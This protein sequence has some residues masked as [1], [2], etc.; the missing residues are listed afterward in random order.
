VE[1]VLAKGMGGSAGV[2]VAGAA[3]AFGVQ[4]ALARLLGV[5]QYGVY[6]FVLSWVGLLILVARLGLDVSAVRFVP[7]Y[8][9]RGEWSLL[10]GLLRTSVLAVA[11]AGIVL[12][13]G[14]ALA[15]RFV[16]DRF[17]GGQPGVGLAAAVLLPLVALSYLVQG[18]VRGAR[19]VVRAELM[20]SIIRPLILIALVALIAFTLGRP[21]AVHAMSANAAGTFVAL[22]LGGYWAARALRAG[23]RNTRPEF[24]L[25]AWT[26][27][28]VPFM[29]MGGMNIILDQTDLLVI[30]IFL[31]PED[32]AIYAAGARVAAQTVFLLTA[33][34]VVIAPLVAEYSA[35][36]RVQELQRAL[37]L[38]AR[39]VLVFA[40]G[41]ALVLI[42]FGRP[43]LGLFGDAF[44]AG[45][46][47]MV[48]LV[49]AKLINA[50]TG[51]VGMVMNMTGHQRV[52]ATI[53]GTCAALNL[54]L[55]LLLTPR[56]GLQG[57][58][59]ATA[60]SIASWNIAMGLFVRYRLG[61]D[62]TAL[63][64]PPARQGAGP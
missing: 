64:R 30:G 60:I 39:G 48:T 38:S 29:L 59:I 5:E 31:G 1:A 9:L 3:L 52:S 61:Y 8:R 58:A 27:T 45:Y 49:V 13:I 35:A 53:I 42:V 26:S 17:V 19:Q 24:D 22:T 21:T 16:P 23:L 6:V 56:F 28:A 4:V 36:G 63:G 51:S 11:T 62:T 10:H 43:I 55:N 15:M 2:K 44:R 40:V 25:P 46:A 7:Q 50:L 37:T 47:P 12:G 32:A 41:V 34:D 20:E 33:A 54:V 18:I 14:L 57:A